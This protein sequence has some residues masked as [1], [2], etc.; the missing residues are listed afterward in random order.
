MIL[1]NLSEH[2]QEL[3][4][5][6]VVSKDLSRMLDILAQDYQR[7]DHSLSRVTAEGFRDSGLRAAYPP[8]GGSNRGA[9]PNVVAS[10]ANRP[11]PA[12]AGNAG[13]TRVPLLTECC[14]EIIPVPANPVIRK[15]RANHQDK[16]LYHLQCIICGQAFRDHRALYT[17]FPV[18]V[19]QRG[20][21]NG[22]RWFD[23]DS[24]EIDKIPATLIRKVRTEAYYHEFAC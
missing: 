7:L 6:G 24:V 16:S 8:N 11:A 4:K 18:C 15:P 12:A 23:H 21:V 1:R 19:Q 14:G 5:R 2:S 17:H 20:N 10:N 22:N 9:A 13:G 3:G